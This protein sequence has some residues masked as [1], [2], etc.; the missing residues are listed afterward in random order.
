MLQTKRELVEELAKYHY[1]Y[2]SNHTRK[3]KNASIEDV[4]E[5]LQVAKDELEF[6]Q[7]LNCLRYY[8]QKP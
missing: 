5:Y 6:L 4:M 7:E 3:W 2:N 8:D 1:E